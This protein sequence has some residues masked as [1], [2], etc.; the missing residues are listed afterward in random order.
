MSKPEVPIEMMPPAVWERYKELLDETGTEATVQRIDI[1]TMVLTHSSDRV[2]FTVKYRN[3]R[4][5]KYQWEQ[6]SSE[7]HIDGEKVATVRYS[8]QYAAIFIDPDG[9]RHTWT[10][11]G[12]KK[13]DVSGLRELTEEQ[14]THAPVQI[15]MTARMFNKMNADAEC[16]VAM[17]TNGASRFTI[18]ISTEGKSTVYMHLKPGVGDWDLDTYQIVNSVG[19]D[20][21][22]WY[23]DD[24]EDLLF[25]VMGIGSRKA[26]VSFDPVAKSHAQA[27]MAN[28]VAVRKNTVI[29]N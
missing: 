15:A 6:H 22:D 7:L 19:Y 28:S 23:G 2:R 1:G 5:H 14:L 9:G 13:A 21:T 27:G 25:E 12:A 26:Q 16:R 20:V 10:P 24:V 8:S 11:K 29:R 18:R 3:H 4:N 17:M